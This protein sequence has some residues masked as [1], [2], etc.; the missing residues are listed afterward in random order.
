M[1]SKI[2]ENTLI[3]ISLVVALVGL[4]VWISDIKSSAES[5]V[6]EIKMMKTDQRDYIKTLN[7]IDKRL[8]NIEGKLGIS[9]R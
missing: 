1:T 5:S 3:P 2:T 4:V 8:A 9:T 6:D 7:Q